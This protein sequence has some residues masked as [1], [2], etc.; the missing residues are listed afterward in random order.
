M[1]L[2]GTLLVPGEAEGEIALRPGRV[3]IEDDRI[4]GVEFSDVAVAG[5]I[6]M[7]GFIDAHLHLPQFDVVGAAGMPLLEWLDGVV[8][9]AE[10][11]WSEPDFAQAMT[12]RVARQ[13]LS[14][15]TTGVAA[16]AT[17]HHE[18]AGRAI[19]VCAEAGLRGYVGQVLMDREAPGEL[20]RPASQLLDE[21]AALQPAGR[22]EPSINPRFAIACT[23]ELLEGAGRLARETGRL[24]QTHLAETEAECA[25]VEALF[26]AGYV[27]VYERAGVLSPRAVLAHA[28]WVGEAD[29]AKLAASGSVAC[30][31]PTANAFL[32]AG[33]MDLG[34]MR[35]GGVR[36]AL[37]S[38][39]AAGPDRSMVRVARTSLDTA[40]A[41]GVEV[42]PAWGWWAITRGNAA[43]LGLTDGGRLE[44][45]AAADLVVVEPELAWR[46]APDPLGALLYGWDDRWIRRVVAAGRTVWEA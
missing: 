34:G 42:P 35:K 19:A 30:H 39:V 29:R 22:I 10:A 3:A 9:P 37:G 20:V 15:G 21:A 23:P 12:R 33:A 44:A 43:A 13:L 28:I 8:F 31:C 17:V 7:P 26:G 24:V 41:R 2:T 45:G 38:D 1:E 32:G 5:P 36:V 16:Y 4:A 11:R 40:R 18:A 27:D 6:I 14:F 46:D 25:R